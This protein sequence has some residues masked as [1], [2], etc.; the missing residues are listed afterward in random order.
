MGRALGGLWRSNYETRVCECLWLNDYAYGKDCKAG[1]NLTTPKTQI[2]G[3]GAFVNFVND[4]DILFTDHR[5]YRHVLVGDGGEGSEALI[6]YELNLEHSMAEANMEIANTTQSV[7]IFGLKV[8]GSNTILW[9]H[10][11]T[12][13]VTLYALG[14]GADAFPDTSY[15]PSDF[16]AYRPSIIRIERTQR[17]K[18]INLFDGGRG[19]AGARTRPIGKF[20]LTEEILSAYPWPTDDVPRIIKSMWAPWPGYAVDPANW[21]LL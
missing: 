7:D 19:N 3:G 14:G 2:R 13:P 16:R 12:G 1:V 21:Q 9:A 15:Y 17:Y 18:M 8:E 5:H 11:A 20:P 6:F 10:D 4:E